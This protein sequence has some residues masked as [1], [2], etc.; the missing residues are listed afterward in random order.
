MV[1]VGLISRDSEADGSF[2]KNVLYDL[3]KARKLTKKTRKRQKD[4]QLFLPRSMLRVT[5]WFRESKGQKEAISTLD[6]SLTG[7]IEILNL[8]PI[9][10]RAYRRNQTDVSFAHVIIVFL[11]SESFLEI[12]RDC[13][14]KQR[15]QGIDDFEITYINE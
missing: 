15:K 3:S 7:T 1:H 11:A 10:S 5:A 6:I 9:P 8:K 4:S 13:Q 12:G 2:C 14:I